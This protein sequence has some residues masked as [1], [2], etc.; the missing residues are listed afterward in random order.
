M[1]N[2]KINVAANL[3]R[4][5]QANRLTI[6]EVADRVGVSRQ[7]IA[8]WEKGASLPDIINCATLAELY[9][10]PVDEL[11]F[12][13]AQDDQPATAPT[14]KRFFGTLTVN[15]NGSLQLPAQARTAYN[16][17]DGAHLTLLGNEVGLALV[18]EHTFMGP[19]KD[20]LKRF[21]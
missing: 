17:R 12:I 1:N 18:P 19:L 9:E 2:R 21:A 11:L 3:R 15:N 8:K 14:R 16:I 20:M 10:V 5:R 6:E 4:L 13:D 7:A